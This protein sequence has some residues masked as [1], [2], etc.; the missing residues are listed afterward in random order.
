MTMP[1]QRVGAATRTSRFVVGLVVQGLLAAAAHAG[2][3]PPASTST[4]TPS[5]TC[6]ATPS[7]T[8][9]AT[10]TPAP[11][12]LSAADTNCDG[13]STAADFV[14]AVSVS[15]DGTDFP[16]CTAAD[17]FRD[18]PLTDEAVLPLLQGLFRTL[19]APWTPTPSASPTVTGTPTITPTPSRTPRPTASRTP[20]VT[21]K[22]T[23]SPTTTPTFTPTPTSTPTATPT[24]TPTATASVT[25]T[26]TATRPP[27]ATHTPTATPVPTGVAYLLSGEW[28]ANWSNTVCF[29]DGQPFATLL[30]QTYRV[31]AVDGRLDIVQANGTR[32]GAGLQFDSNGTVVFT[33][34]A[35]D[36]RICLI[37]GTHQE[38]VFDYTFTF[39]LNGT[40]SAAARWSY[41]L[42]TNCAV[43]SFVDDQAVLV[44]VSGP[45]T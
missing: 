7:A 31:T 22:P 18:Q 8:T 9:I 25:P 28:R 36:Q 29:L 19:D 38:F 16:G 34:R 39:R 27:T 44:R 20:T 33:Y 30:D 43:C 13:A 10:A 42:N 41:G 5:P 3:P 26:I 4:C 12:P 21:P 6:S 1:P 40:G 45:G 24:T 35:F 23:P 11:T 15:D 2:L 17:P 37:N 32:I 14:A